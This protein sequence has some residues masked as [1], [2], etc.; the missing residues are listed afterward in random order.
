MPLF[1]LFA[2]LLSN[3]V[4]STVQAQDRSPKGQAQWMLEH[5]TGVKWPADAPILTSMTSRISSGDVAGAAELAIQQPQ[6]L[7]VMVKQMALKMSTREE[8]IRLSFNDFAASFI[9]VARDGTDARELLYGNFYYMANPVQVSGI[10]SDLNADILRS[11]KHYDALAK[12]NVDYGAVLMRVN[13][14]M[15]ATGDK[16][17]T[18]VI[19]S[20][21]PAGVLTSRTWLLAHATAGTNRRLVEYTFREFMCV[22]LSEWADTQAPDIRVGRDIDRMPGNIN[23]KY[24]TS[25]KGC[26]AVQDAFRGAFAK[27]DWNSGNGVA[28]Y[29]VSGVATKMNQNNKV[30]PQGFVTTDDSWLNH[31]RRGSNANLFGFRGLAPDAIGTD[32]SG[33]GA[34]SFGR[35]VANSQRFSQCMAQHVFQNVCQHALSD[36]DA[37]AL[38]MSLGKS[39]ENYGYNLKKLFELVASH[40]FCRI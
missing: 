7:N 1:I 17:S 5:L 39:F 22:A 20:G 6:F 38:Y 21:D 10:P 34:N 36:S 32:V 16:D 3:M 29:K 12:A 4:L 23:S 9:G 30:Y 11:N 14:Q 35:L 31:A 37:Q 40:P 2:F 33:R 19:P 28:E 24:E 15:L 8:T 26:H 25:C 18:S 27:W 13:G